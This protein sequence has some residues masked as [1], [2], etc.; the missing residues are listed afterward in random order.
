MDD[1][2]ITMDEYIELQVEKAHR[3][4]FPAIIYE[5]ALASDREISSKPTV[6]DIVIEQSEN[7]IDANVDTQSHEFDKDFETNHDIHRITKMMIN[8]KAAYELKGKFLDDFWNN[9]FSRTNGEDAVEHIENFLK[10]VDPI[11]L[12][13]LSTTWVDLTE[14]FFG[15]YYP[16]SRTGKIMGTKAK[17]DS[18]N[19][20]FEHW[21]ASKFTN[22][23]MMDPFTKNAI[24]DYW[25]KGDDHEVLTKEAINT[26]IFDFE[27]PL[28]TAFNEFNFLLKIDTDLFTHDIQE[29][30][31]C[32]E[33]ENELNNDPVEP[34]SENRVPYELIDHICELI[35]FKN[36]KSKWSTCCSNEDEFC[37][38]GELPGMR[39]HI[40]RA[41]AKTN[42][43]AN[44][45]PYLDVSRTFN[46]HAGKNDEETIREERKPNDDHGNFDNNLVRDNVH[47]HASEEEE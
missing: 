9:A 2:N 14:L 25:K 34:W 7:G 42:I 31:T 38:G 30:K 12:P 4:D 47:Y 5:D 45:N 10:I 20:V 33:Y 27:T 24:W 19:E 1:P 15:K 46:N 36:G 8:G 29:A 21:L 22:H 11:D 26:G 3:H 37:N 18:T 43:N 35:H 32:E 39:K 23:M 41:Y 16:P 17:W 6:S 13:N 28:C 44:Y 40:R